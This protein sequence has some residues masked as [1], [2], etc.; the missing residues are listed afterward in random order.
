MHDLIVLHRYWLAA[1][2]VKQFIAAKLP[3]RDTTKLPKDLVGVA[4]IWSGVLRMQVFYGL[5]YVVIEGYRE[6]DCHDAAL[7]ELLSQTHYVEALR[8]FRN[9]TFHFQKKFVSPKLLA[10]SKLKTATNG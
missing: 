10:F 5:M 2:A 7:D 9:A 1:D 4:E 8:R 3:G 6:L